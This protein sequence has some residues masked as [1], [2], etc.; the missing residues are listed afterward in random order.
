MF[1]KYNKKQII[2]VLN[3]Y[4]GSSSDYKNPLL[5]DINTYIKDNNK[6]A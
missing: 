6:K 2:E 5:F 1:G 3:D 4:V